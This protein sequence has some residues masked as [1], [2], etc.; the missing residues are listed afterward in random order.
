ML[1]KARLREREKLRDRVR[2]RDRKDREREREK[3][4]EVRW[5]RRKIECAECPIPPEP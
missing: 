4:I 3:V 1:K 2:E 5:E